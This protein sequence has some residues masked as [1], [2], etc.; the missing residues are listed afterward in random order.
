MLDF[1]FEPLLLEVIVPRDEKD[2]KEGRVATLLEL[3]LGLL[4]VG[5][6]RNCS[7]LSDF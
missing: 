5:C 4:L 7:L 6:G 2:T 3:I 1:G